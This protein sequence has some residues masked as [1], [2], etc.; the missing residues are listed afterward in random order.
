MPAK[1]VLRR[2]K[3]TIHDDSDEGEFQDVD[4]RDEGR[5]DKKMGDHSDDDDDDGDDDN[6]EE[7]Q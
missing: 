2:V 7:V 4:E 1:S 6:E 5:E 3:P